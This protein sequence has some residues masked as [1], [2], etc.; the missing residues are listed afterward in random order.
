[1]NNQVKKYLPVGTVVLLNNGKKSLMIIGFCSVDSNDKTQTYDYMGVLYPEGLISSEEIA[2]FNHNDINKILHMGLV[3]Q[4]ETDFKI[5]LN[6]FVNDS[7]QQLS[8]SEPV[9]ESIQSI[10]K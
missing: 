1:M 5:A 9:I 2:M 6:E 10:Q 7:Q 4:E 8:S 3:N